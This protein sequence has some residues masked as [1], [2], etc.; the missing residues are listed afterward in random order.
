MSD[1]HRYTSYRWYSLFIS[2]CRSRIDVFVYA[3]DV[4]CHWTVSFSPPEQNDPQ[5]I[6]RKKKS[7]VFNTNERRF[8]VKTSELHRD[9]PRC[10]GAHMAEDDFCLTGVTE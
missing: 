8:M 2:L 7:I 5:L 1:I 4:R 3:G 6:R 10:S 9:V